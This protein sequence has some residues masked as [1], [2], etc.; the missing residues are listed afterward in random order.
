MVVI[1][2][3]PM[4]EASEAGGHFANP[5]DLSVVHV[6]DGAPRDMQ[7]ARDNG[8]FAARGLRRRQA[9]R[10]ARGAGVGGHWR[11]PCHRCTSGLTRN[12]DRN[13]PSEFAGPCGKNSARGGGARAQTTDGGC[14]RTQQCVLIAFDGNLVFPLAYSRF[15][16]RGV[17]EREKYTEIVL[18]PGIDRAP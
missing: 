4:K 10:C 12:R 17:G 7:D 1:A 8:F 5:R 15:V 2:P 16:H 6:T 18:K 3:I 14:F 9:A 11:G 13:L